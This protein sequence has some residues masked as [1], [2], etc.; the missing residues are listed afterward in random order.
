MEEWKGNQKNVAS[1]GNRFIKG[2]GFG[3]RIASSE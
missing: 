1:F 3:F 2:L